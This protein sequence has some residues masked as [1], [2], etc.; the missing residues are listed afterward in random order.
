M[1]LKTDYF[2]GATGLHLKE[3]EAFDAGVTFIVTTNVAAISTALKASAAAGITKFTTTLTTSYQN[4]YL[5]GNNGNNLQ[6]KSYLNGI[7][8]GLSDQGIFEFECTPSLNIS[9]T[10]T[11]KIDLNFDF[12]TT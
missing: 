6:L 12:Q 7:S 8:K 11:T 10:L 9:D 5:R 1:S 2:D 4:T 3:Q